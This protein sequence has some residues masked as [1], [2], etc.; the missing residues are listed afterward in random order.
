MNKFVLFAVIVV[1]V[2]VVG[3]TWVYERNEPK[4]MTPF[5]DSIAPFFP[6]AAE[7]LIAACAGSAGGPRGEPGC[8]EALDLIRIPMPVSPCPINSL[9][10]A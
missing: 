6:T 9:T 2:M 5:I 1:V 3:F 7:I 8:P 10:P 4:F